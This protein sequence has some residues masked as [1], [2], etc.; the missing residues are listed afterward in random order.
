MIGNN[1]NTVQFFRMEFFRPTM[2]KS[3]L[4]QPLLESKT[5][6]L[7]RRVDRDERTF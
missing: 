1:V 4:K 3:G 6:F 7:S 2:A 5:L